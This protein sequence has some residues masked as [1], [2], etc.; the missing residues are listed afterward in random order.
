MEQG[1]ASTVGMAWHG[2]GQGEERFLTRAEYEA[3]QQQMPTTDDQLVMHLLTYTG[4]GWGEM[5][6]LHWDRVDLARA[7]C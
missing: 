1:R 6:G 5:A 7:A 3:I 4:L 2:S